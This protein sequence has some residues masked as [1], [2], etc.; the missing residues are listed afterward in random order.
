[1]KPTFRALRSRNYRLWVSGTVVSN[2]GTWMQRTAQDW[3]V[4]TVLTNHSGFA[5]G[6]ATGLQFAPLLLFSAHAGVLA[7]RLPKRR[8]LM[9]TQSLMGLSAL[10]LGLLVVTHQVR[11]WHV[12][13]CALLLGIGSALDNP[14]RQ[15]FVSEVV[16]RA[17][18]TSAVSLNSA[19]M[20]IARLIGPG[21]AGVIIE[22]AGTGPGF[23][24]NAA[25]FAAVLIALVRM[26]PGEMYASQPLP[27]G[28]GQVRAGLRYVRERPDLILVFFSTGLVSMFALN[29]QV[30][31]A[32]MASGAFH[33]GAR[34]YGLLGSAMA[35]G[36]LTAAL[37]NARRE[38]PRLRLV[39][40]SGLALGTGMTVS[41]LM[42]GY[43]LY[44]LLLVPVGLSMITF[45]NSCN[46]SVQLSTD[47][48]L[49]GR[50]IA[51]YVTIQQGTTP[52][53]APIVGWLGSAF[54]ARWS[55]LTGGF[56]ALL[57]GG[58]GAVLLATRPGISRRFDAAVAGP[59]T[60]VVEEAEVGAG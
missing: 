52:F 11:L 30:T 6:V 18:V 10:I 29:F 33:R 40:G 46:T 37:I 9:F 48:Q 26:R 24:L 7:D 14:C 51:L 36:C 2:T 3:L 27:R 21:F 25:S 38:R 58:V 28:R 4:L 43:A 23:L 49:R 57:A 47:P 59:A 41:A 31:N 54:G 60:T 20:N 50:V 56:A 12:F 32:L 17:D 22:A 44:A 53:G 8:V 42:P 45:L 34:E 1:V 35:I 39:V 16:P 19:S 55:V 5:T 13:V 15:A